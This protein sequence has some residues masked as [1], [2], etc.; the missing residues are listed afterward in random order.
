M[1]VRNFIR[2]Y[3]RGLSLSLITLGLTGTLGLS[4]GLSTPVETG[5]KETETA[6][7]DA[8]SRAMRIGY[9][10][11]AQRDYH[12][13]LINFRR[14]LQLN[15]DDPYAQA[16]VENVEFYI[17]R[18]RMAIIQREINALE[19]RL[20]AANEAKDWVC[21]AATVD[22][23]ITY[24]ESNSLNRQRLLGYRGELSGLLDARANLAAWST[25]CSPHQPLL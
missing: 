4:P 12:T 3:G 15:P 7:E 2:S 1:N 22:E 5:A 23:L 9:A 20:A 21:A 25:V 19:T 10:A 18:D 14:A 6:P 8:F 16:A 11:T 17:E 24:T 13:A